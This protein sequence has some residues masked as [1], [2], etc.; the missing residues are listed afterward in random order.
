MN[1][2]NRIE[3]LKQIGKLLIEKYKEQFVLFGV[4]GSTALNQTTKY[5]D[6]E[7]ICILTGEFKTKDIHFIYKNRYFHSWID[8]KNAIENNLKNVNLLWSIEMGH[9]QI[10]KLIYGN[11][12]YLTYL[13]SIGD[14]I[15][16]NTFKKV[17]ERNLPLLF[18]IKDKFKSIKVRNDISKL[19]TSIVLSHLIFNTN[20][21]LGLL[22]RKPLYGS[23]Y[24]MLDC[25]LKFEILPKNYKKEILE[26]LYTIKIDK[27]IELSESFIQKFIAFLRTKGI[28]FQPIDRL[29]ELPNLFRD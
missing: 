1:Q 19:D 26:M 28:E 20:L 6:I 24:R 5:S 18:D 12:D 23:G 16:K 14:K 7:A 25:V 27:L 4:A 21:I 8:S 29:K 15:P 3:I 11:K 17:I 10:M 9:F 13:R 22:N 2:K